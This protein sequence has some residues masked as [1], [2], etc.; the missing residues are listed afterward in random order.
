MSEHNQSCG[1]VVITDE[2]P[3]VINGADMR[4]IVAKIADIR[5]CAEH[6]AVWD[7]GIQRMADLIDREIAEKVYPQASAQGDG[8]GE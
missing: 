5:R 6:Q 8:G 4:G 7:A 3:V 1:C 2:S